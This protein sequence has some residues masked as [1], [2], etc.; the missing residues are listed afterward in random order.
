VR[1]VFFRPYEIT[2]QSSVE[3]AYF[4]II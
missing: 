2:F 3:Y 1:G 4:L